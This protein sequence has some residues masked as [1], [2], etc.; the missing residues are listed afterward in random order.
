VSANLAE[1]LARQIRRVAQL[2]GTYAQLR[3]RPG[4]NVDF[5]LLMI[6]AALEA[7][8]K[9]AGVD[10]AVAQ[11]AAFQQLGSIEE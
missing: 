11:L 4:V 9:A 3:G 5:A 2:R 10:D 6:D 1:A 7:A 8:C